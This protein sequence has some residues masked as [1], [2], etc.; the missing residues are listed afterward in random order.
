MPQSSQKVLLVGCKLQ[1]NQIIVKTS[2]INHNYKTSC[3]FMHIGRHCTL[4]FHP[5]LAIST[6][7]VFHALNEQSK[8]AHACKLIRPW[9]R[10]AIRAIFCAKRALSAWKARTP[11]SREW[12]H[13][14]WIHAGWKYWLLFCNCDVL[15]LVVGLLSNIFPATAWSP[16]G[17][18]LRVGATLGARD[19][20]ASWPPELLSWSHWST[21]VRLGTSQLW[22]HSALRQRYT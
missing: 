22:I 7:P 10:S 3:A 1:T 2:S 15:L 9:N 5:F 16:F 6:F 17:C 20:V 8:Y 11:G 14:H 19:Q 18:L 13:P 12:W 21:C 4:L